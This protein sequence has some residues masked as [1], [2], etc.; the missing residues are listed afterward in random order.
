MNSTS[1]IMTLLGCAVFQAACGGGSSSATPSPPP[2]P[3]A[4]LSTG[5]ADCVG[6]LAADF[7]CSG[8]ALR[9]R[10]PNG[11]M[12]GGNGNDIWG[13]VDPMDAREYAIMGLTNGVA[14]VDV[15]DPENPVFLGRLPT[16]TVDSTW[17]DMKVYFN[18]AF[19]VADGASAHGMQVFDLTRLRNVAAPQ[20]FTA[21]AIYSLFTN[22]HN[23]AINE[24]TGF[25]YAV[26]T[27]TCDEG[28]HMVDIS[29][30]TMPVMAGCYDEADIH[31]TQCVS[32]QGPDADYAGR[33]ICFNSAA[34]NTTNNLPVGTHNLGIV[35]VTV[36]SAPVTVFELD[37]PQA[38]FAHQG[39][40][41]E[42][43][44]FFL[45]GDE[46]DETTFSV[47]TRTHV[48]D[49]TDLDAPLYVYAFDAAT[50]SIDHNLYVFG[51]RVYQANYTSGVRILE[52]N[53][54]AN[55]DLMEVGFFDTFPAS[56][57]TG[58]DGV[59]SVYPFFP[60]GNII[61]S[62]DANGLFVLTPQ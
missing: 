37:Y 22:A 45:L 52:F 38:G 4:G 11:D 12:G 35:D 43:H 54:L 21:D 17:R 31:D 30:P 28:L 18:H 59:W 15:S 56:D 44:R 46:A 27:N 33:E 40:L 34:T 16:N 36:K 57:A 5:P 20:E 29:I 10:V 9:K 2:P 49:V 6:S 8:I 60:S 14:F 32:Y 42:D 39:W 53:N 24:D 50:T 1:R 7:A 19:V 51:N 26:G 41:T 48:F 25:A 47:P 23:L 62:D 3:A 55:M 61:A 58:F 13:W